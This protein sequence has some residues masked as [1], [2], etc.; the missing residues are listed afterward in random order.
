MKK[1]GTWVKDIKG[2]EDDMVDGIDTQ[3]EIEAKK[4]AKE[5]DD[6]LTS[7]VGE[8]SSH[9]TYG[10][11]NNQPDRRLENTNLPMCLFASGVYIAARASLGTM[12]TRSTRTQ[13][14]RKRIM[15]L[16]IEDFG[17]TGSM[18]V[19]KS[20]QEPAMV[21]FQRNIINIMES[22]RA[23][24]V[25]KNSQIDKSQVEW[26]GRECD[27]AITGTD[28]HNQRRLGSQDQS[29]HRDESL[30][31]AMVDRMGRHRTEQIHDLE[32]WPHC[33]PQHHRQVIQATRCQLWRKGLVHAAQD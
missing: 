18:I 25:P 22:R 3:G 13:R 14:T 31:H 29:G 24:T 12:H 32:G 16:D 27:Q 7:E 33:L 6:E 20:D 21:D 30:D 19:V 9:D 10:S 11:L 23:E 26:R 17:Y 1:S 2:L 28:P 5:E 8:E 4:G 15:L